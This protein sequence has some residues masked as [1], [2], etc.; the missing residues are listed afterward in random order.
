MV[1]MNLPVV[2]CGP[3]IE[4]LP[5]SNNPPIPLLLFISV[6]I[7]VGY[8]RNDACAGITVSRRVTMMMNEKRVLSRVTTPHGELQLQQALDRHDD[9]LPV[10]EIIFNGVFLM[11]SY[12][13]RSEKALARYAIDA[14]DSGTSTLSILIGGLGIGYT[15]RAALD[16]ES[17]AVI[18]V[19]EIDKHVEQWARTYFAEHNG[20][21]LSD[22]RVRLIRANI[23][24]YVTKAGTAY[25]AI[26]LDVDNGPARLA[27]DGNRDL[28]ESPMMNTIKNML[29]DGGVLAVWSAHRCDNFQKRLED[30]FHTTDVVTIQDFDRRGNPTDYFIYRGRR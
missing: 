10:Y 18:D 15:L 28:Y 16:Y 5:N 20:A 26:I 23:K 29:T 3:S 19:V 25:N 7:A 24:D 2:T 1:T 27:L 4:P 6:K 11:A 9:S 30:I 13:I 12:N 14:L 22:P 8:N 17:V 21:A